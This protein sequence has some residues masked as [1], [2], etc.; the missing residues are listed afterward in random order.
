MDL[1][2]DE[3]FMNEA[4]KEAQK[5]FA[6]QAFAL[7]SYQDRQLTETELEEFL[8]PRR[9]EDEGDS[10]LILIFN[11]VNF[12]IFLFALSRN[13]DFNIFFIVKHQYIVFI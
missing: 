4:L 2:T 9:K 1:Y 3:Y 5:A 11:P 7:R 13:V 8:A 10:L 6:Q 12:E